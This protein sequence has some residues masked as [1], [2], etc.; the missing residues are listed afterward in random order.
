[1]TIHTTR[2]G[3]AVPGPVLLALST[4]RQSDAAVA[5]ALERARAGD[6]RLVIVH[7]VDVNLA[8]YLIGSD[9]GLYGALETRCE[10][11]LL[12]EH[13]ETGRR[14]VAAL[15]DRARAAG[16][17]VETHLRCGRFAVV[18]LELVAQGRPALIV[19]TRA[20]RPEWVRRFFGSP[21][22]EL[23]RRAGCPVIT[24]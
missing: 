1:M 21:V 19:T 23:T 3:A 22:D 15:A 24:A 17:T 14:R 8:R 9:A 4:F 11:D 13:E 16:L 12:R 18:C 5:L 2:E 6:G 10:E 20:R 7:V